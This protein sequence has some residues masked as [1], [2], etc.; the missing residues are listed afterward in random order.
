MFFNIRSYS[1][2][3]SILFVGKSLRRGRTRAKDN[4]RRQADRLDRSDL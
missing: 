1:K 4:N 2:K 3:L